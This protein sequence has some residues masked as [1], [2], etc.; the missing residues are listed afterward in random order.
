MRKLAR[1]KGTLQKKS[2]VYVYRREVIV[3]GQIFVQCFKTKSMWFSSNAHESNW[4]KAV[5]PV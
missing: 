5:N 4:K 1:T 2:V 3:S